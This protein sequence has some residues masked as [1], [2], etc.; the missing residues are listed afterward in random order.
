VRSVCENLASCPRLASLD[1]GGWSCRK[2]GLLSD[3]DRFAIVLRR[4]F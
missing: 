1:L 4:E 3:S 2:Y